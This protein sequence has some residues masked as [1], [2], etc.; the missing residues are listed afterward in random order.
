VFLEY[1]KRSSPDAVKRLDPIDLLDTQGYGKIYA[2]LPDLE[3][4]GYIWQLRFVTEDGKNYLGQE[5][6]FN[7][8]SPATP[9]AIKP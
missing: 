1:A 5:Q 2:L 6:S 3:P 9:S 4:G 8:P 7:T